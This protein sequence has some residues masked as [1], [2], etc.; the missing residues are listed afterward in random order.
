MFDDLTLNKPDNGYTLVALSSGL[1]NK[2]LELVQREQH[3]PRR[4]PPARNLHPYDHQREREPPGRRRRHRHHGRDPNRG[5]SDPGTPMDG[6]RAAIPR[7]TRAAP[8]YTPP[9][10]SADWYEFL[11]QPADGETFDRTKQITGPS[12][13]RRPTA[14]PGLLLGT[15]RVPNGTQLRRPA[16]SSPRRRAGFRT[17]PQG[18]VRLLPSRRCCG[19]TKTWRRGRADQVPDR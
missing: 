10:A 7:P 12:R 14:F 19:A 1:T 8:T 11:V 13:A 15:V 18:S 4:A 5:R 17:A 6:A 3:C 2:N 16:S 9:A